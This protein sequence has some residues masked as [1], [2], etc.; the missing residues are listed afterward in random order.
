M[1]I[2]DTIRSLAG[3]RG[4]TV[5]LVADEVAAG[6]AG[7]GVTALIAAVKASIGLRLR[8]CCTDTYLEAV[9]ELSQRDSC[10]ALLSRVLGEPSKPF[11]ERA[12]FEDQVDAMVASR[13]GIDTNQCLFLRR[14]SDGRV[15]FAALWPWS[16]GVTVTLKVGVY[17]DDV[18]PRP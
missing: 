9:L 16:N 6:E 2:L 15:V 3:T 8:D 12:V 18:T 4:R 13:G 10:V 14:Y 1:G 11:G 7:A 17:D 5:T